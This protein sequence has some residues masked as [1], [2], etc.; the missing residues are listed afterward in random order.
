[1]RAL[2]TIALAAALLQGPAAGAPP[3]AAPPLEGRD[4]RG[5]AVRLSD[6]KGKVVLVNFW[7]TWCP[8]CR[9]EVP[10]LVRWQTAYGPRGLQVIGV[11]VAPYSRGAVRAFAR[12]SKVNYPVVFA[13]DGLATR[14]GA[15]EVMPT[16][17]IVG[18]DGSV[19]GRILGM[20]SPEEFDEQV[21][22]LL[23]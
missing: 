14:F 22:P 12:K 10:D 11:T 3:P 13:A 23:R 2:T 16:T 7:A 17:V 4:L 5:R 15:E 8:P 1:M 19:R 21:V 20:I 18:R 9:A 6:Y